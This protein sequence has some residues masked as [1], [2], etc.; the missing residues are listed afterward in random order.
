M[1]EKRAEMKVELR[2]RARAIKERGGGG[3][4][5][6]RKRFG[7]PPAEDDEGRLGIWEIGV[8]DKRAFI[9]SDFYFFLFFNG[10][11]ELGVGPR[12]RAQNKILNRVIQ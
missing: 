8:A 7:R 5:I 6:T 10:R 1:E 11:W 9:Y 12:F 3:G 4:G 2:R